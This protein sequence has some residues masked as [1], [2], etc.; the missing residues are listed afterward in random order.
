LLSNING[1]IESDVGGGNTGGGGGGGM[2]VV[3]IAII[4]IFLF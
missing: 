2:L 3:C 4:S 1:T